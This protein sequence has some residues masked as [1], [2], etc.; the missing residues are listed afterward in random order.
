MTIWASLSRK[1]DGVATPGFR[2]GQETCGFFQEVTGSI[3][4]PLGNKQSKY[5]QGQTSP[6]YPR[7]EGH[8]W[9]PRPSRLEPIGGLAG[10]ETQTPEEA[11]SP[12]P[13][14]V[15]PS[16]PFLKGSRA[17]QQP[18]S[19]LFCPLADIH[20]HLLCAQHHSGCCGN[21]R[22]G[23]ALDLQGPRDCRGGEA[24]PSAMAGHVGT[25]CRGK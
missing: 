23:Q 8:P 11:A 20:G 2:G 4:R 14:G 9:S 25:G 7:G 17:C 1:G 21:K 22:H 3:S 5:I 19:F 13:R 15:P 24:S 6:P 18:W 10:Q 16:L 12:L